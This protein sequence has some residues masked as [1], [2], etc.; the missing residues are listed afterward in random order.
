MTIETG[1]PNKHSPHVHAIATEHGVRVLVANEP[2]CELV[3]LRIRNGV[4][5]PIECSLLMSHGELA[6]LHEMIGRAIAVADKARE[7]HDAAENV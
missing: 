2:D 3:S 5:G 4:W 1:Y 7:K 6:E